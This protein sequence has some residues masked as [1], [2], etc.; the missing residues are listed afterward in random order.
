MLILDRQQRIVNVNTAMF[1][2]QEGF[3]ESI[4]SVCKFIRFSLK[5]RFA[6]RLN[7]N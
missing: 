4:K 6:K 7:D 5:C 2:I 3:K 1:K